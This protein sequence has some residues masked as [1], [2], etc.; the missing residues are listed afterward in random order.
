[1]LLLVHRARQALHAMNDMHDFTQLF[2]VA[3]CLHAL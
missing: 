3:L 1:M 2:D